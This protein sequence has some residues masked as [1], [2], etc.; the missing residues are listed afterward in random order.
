MLAGI[1]FVHAGQRR[2]ALMHGQH[3]AFGQNVELGVRYNGGDFDDEIVLGIEPGHFQIN[4]DQIV[5]VFHA[6]AGRKK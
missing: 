1:P 3:R 6:D 2:I 4:P 5:I